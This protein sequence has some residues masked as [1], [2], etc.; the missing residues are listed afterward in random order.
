MFSGNDVI[1]F[2]PFDGV[3]FMKP[4]IF[5]TIASSSGN[6]LALGKGNGHEYDV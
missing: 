5:A 2:V 3:I 1:R 6:P 4:T